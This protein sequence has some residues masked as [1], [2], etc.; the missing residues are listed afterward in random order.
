MPSALAMMEEVEKT[1]EKIL[2]GKV[3]YEAIV[4][5]NSKENKSV[6]YAIIATKLINQ[7]NIYGDLL[8][9]RV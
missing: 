6:E 3:N 4:A 5:S 8:I 2:S 7:V 9:Q 1:Y